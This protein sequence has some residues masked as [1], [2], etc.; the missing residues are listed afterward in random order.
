MKQPEIPINERKRQ[1]ALDSYQIL[2]TLPEEDLDN[3]TKLAS[4][5][6]QTPISYI[7]LI[8]RDRQ[9]FKSVQ[10]MDAGETPREIAFCAH[11]INTPNEIFVVPDSREDERFFDNPLVTGVPYVVFYTGVPLVNPDGF[12]LGTLC[13][14]DQQP[15]TLI[16]S[17]IDALKILAKQTMK[18]FELHKSNHELEK[19]KIILENRNKDLEKFAFVVS[20]DLKSPL[21]SIISMIELFL[22]DNKEHLDEK[23]LKY[24]DYISKSSFRL[25]DLIEGIL[26]YY[27]SDPVALKKPE[28][29][30]TEEFFNSLFE[31][32][33][34]PA[35]NT[36]I[37]PEKQ[38]IIANK[39]ALQQ[40]FLNLLSNSIRYNNKPHLILKIKLRED[41]EKYHFE[42]KDNGV[43]IEE[44]DKEKIFD[45]FTTLHGKDIQGNHSTGIGLST[46]KKLVT[47]LGG[48]IEVNSTPNVQT[49]F[50]FSLR[51]Y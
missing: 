46:V 8:D 33:S 36:V 51:K 10:G 17:Q 16:K 34:F 28:P 38:T 1:K 3:I 44:K 14:V 13:I 23:G 22:L 12:A 18:L 4:E 42:V 6:C 40:I 9:W 25:K 30:D 2:D 19:S 37:I 39:T 48:T 50:S 49:T 11:A 15:R 24:M 26:S 21:T 45:L 47:H 35:D 41:P 43:G 5:I 20:H 29:I 27:R 31:M 32:I 7:S